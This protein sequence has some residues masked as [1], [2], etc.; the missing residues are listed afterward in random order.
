MRAAARSG[1]RGAGNE[2]I[3]RRLGLSAR[4]VAVH[5]AALLRANALSSRTALVAQHLRGRAL[6]PIDTTTDP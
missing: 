4:T 5:L 1:G 6:S 3:G 2:T